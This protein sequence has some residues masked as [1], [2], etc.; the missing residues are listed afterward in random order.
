VDLAGRTCIVCIAIRLMP[1][2]PA[3]SPQMNTARL[4][5]DTDEQQPSAA[6]SVSAA[7]PPL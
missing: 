7:T 5:R 2:R 4:R 1:V 6:P 3:V